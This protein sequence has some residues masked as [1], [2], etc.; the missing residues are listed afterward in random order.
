ATP[1]TQDA[2]SFALGCAAPYPLLDAML[3][4]VLEA[5][6]LHRAPSADPLS[7]FDAAA[8]GGE[9][10]PCVRA[11]A[12]AL[13]HPRVFVGNL[14]HGAEPVGSPELS[15]SRSALGLSRPP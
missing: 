9:E 5:L 6:V 11:A 1:L 2:T 12:T 4:R 15:V 13:E 8:V 7:S 3:Q 10:R 14:V